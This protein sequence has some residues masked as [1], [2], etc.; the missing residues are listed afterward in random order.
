MKKKRQQSDTRYELPGASCAGR[1]EL[2]GMG[3]HSSASTAFFFFFIELC[4]KK[5]KKKLKRQTRSEKGLSCPGNGLRCFSRGRRQSL[6][7]FLCT[8][9]SR[10]IKHGN[11]MFEQKTLGK[12]N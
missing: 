2:D 9:Q 11:F 8:C 10:V 6:I 7:C 5:E 1:L 3:F 12:K 4:P